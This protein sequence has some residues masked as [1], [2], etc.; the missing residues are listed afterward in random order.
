MV[1]TNMSQVLNYISKYFRHH[2]S[3]QKMEFFISNLEHP[4]DMLTIGRIELT[5]LPNFFTDISAL[6]RAVEN[7]YSNAVKAT[8]SEGDVAVLFAYYPEKQLQRIYIADSGCGIS[9]ERQ[10]KLFQPGESGFAK[11]DAGGTGYG[12][13]TNKAA[14]HGV[15]GD[16]ELI[17]S[18]EGGGSVFCLTIPLVSNDSK[19]AL[20]VG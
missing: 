15:G 4:V 3:K 8:A 19:K 1:E 6:L 11:T 13:Y 7:L 17:W 2:K 12:L 9:A 20:D 16:I 10:T 14:M 5:D 18:K